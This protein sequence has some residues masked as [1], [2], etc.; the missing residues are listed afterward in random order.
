MAALT[1]EALGEGESLA[2]RWR[3]ASRAMI[4]SLPLELATSRAP[5]RKRAIVRMTTLGKQ[6]A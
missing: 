6:F 2:A 3:T 5:S 1:P 4:A